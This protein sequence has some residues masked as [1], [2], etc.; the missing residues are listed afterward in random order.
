MSA[1]NTA[2]TYTTVNNTIGAFAIIL[3]NAASQPVVTGATL[4]P[5]AIFVVSTDMH[6]VIQYFGVTVQYY[7]L[8]L[9]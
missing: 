2:I 8:E 5:G 4:L 1:A 7:F 9:S 6:L 3:I